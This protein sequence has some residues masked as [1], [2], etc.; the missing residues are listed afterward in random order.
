MELFAQPF[1]QQLFQPFT[2]TI[3]VLGSVEENGTSRRDMD[4]KKKEMSQGRNL[5]FLGM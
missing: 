5:P 1:T 3:S 2:Q 4:E